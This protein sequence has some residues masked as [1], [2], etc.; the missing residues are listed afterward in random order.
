MAKTTLSL[1]NI[2]KPAPKAFRKW[3]KAI[4]IL[5]AA[6]N[7]MI[8]SWGL[9]DE[10]L[11]AHLQLWCTVG[12]GALMEALETLLANGEEY[13]QVADEKENTDMEKGTNEVAEHPVQ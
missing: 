5:I 9:T 8:A 2:T 11:V 6:A 4:L 10:L 13:T 3:K 12:I 1:S 7:V